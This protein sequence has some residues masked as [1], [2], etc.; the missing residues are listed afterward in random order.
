M[1]FSVI[2]LE[3]NSA[4]AKSLA[5][6]LSSPFQ[7]VLMTNSSD[8]LR[9]RI[10]TERPNAVVLDMECSRLIDV[11]HLH[12]DFP[13]LPIVCTH[14]HP[15]DELWIAALEAGASDVCRAEDVQNSLASILQSVPRANRAFA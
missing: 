11:R 6:E 1:G 5:G 14:R 9:Q 12:R 8:E 4:A 3:S 2:V 15:D 10:A 13:A 7:S